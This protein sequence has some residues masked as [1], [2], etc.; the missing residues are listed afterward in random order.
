[1]K[2][3]M[4]L[5][6]YGTVNIG[7]NIENNIYNINL[8]KELNILKENCNDI[9][10]KEKIDKIVDSVKKNKR[11]EAKQFFSKLRKS[12]LNLIKELSLSFIIDFIKSM[13]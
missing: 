11:E 13:I 7:E 3:N 4:N 6:N 12:T 2:I 8:I 9:K 5:K 10:D 1:M